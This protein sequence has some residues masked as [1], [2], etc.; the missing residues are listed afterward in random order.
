MDSEL[1]GRHSFHLQSDSC[2]SRGAGW[3][4]PDVFRNVGYDPEVWSG[5]AFGLGIERIA[6]L[7]H[8]LSDLR[9]F[10]ENDVRMLEQ[11]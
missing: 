8:G 6:L 3:V 1:V 10:W 4:D 7:R 11:F 2:I 9:L 5:F